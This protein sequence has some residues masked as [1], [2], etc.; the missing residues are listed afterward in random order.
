MIYDYDDSDDGSGG[1]GGSDTD[2]DDDDVHVSFEDG[3]QT[4]FFSLSP[5]PPLLCKQT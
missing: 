5:P 4:I 1:G 2:D 3:I